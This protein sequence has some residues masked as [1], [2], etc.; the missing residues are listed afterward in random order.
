M[1]GVRFGGRDYYPAAFTQIGL[2]LL[3][4]L[5]RESSRANEISIFAARMYAAQHRSEI[6]DRVRKY[7][8]DSNLKHLD[9]YNA[10][11]VLGE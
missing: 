9:A 2:I 7:E 4:G 6:F 11:V 8:R 3:A 5:L 1:N 10:L